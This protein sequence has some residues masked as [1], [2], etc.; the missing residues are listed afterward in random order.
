MRCTTKNEPKGDT[1]E[2]SQ[3][4]PTTQS[5]EN[6]TWARNLDTLLAFQMRDEYN[7]K[8]KPRRK[9]ACGKRWGKALGIDHLDKGGFVKLVHRILGFLEFCFLLHRT[10]D[11]VHLTNILLT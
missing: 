6:I 2:D 1:A 8:W 3:L 4:F 10:G 5:K 7:E 9:V 11:I